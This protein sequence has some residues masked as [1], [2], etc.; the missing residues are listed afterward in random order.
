MRVF[1]CNWNAPGG[2][3]EGKQYTKNDPEA[4]QWAYCG[5][6]ADQSVYSSVTGT[7][8]LEYQ[9]KEPVLYHC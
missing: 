5:S 1:S 6:T 7:L 8:L 9:D 3:E 2:Q 4:S